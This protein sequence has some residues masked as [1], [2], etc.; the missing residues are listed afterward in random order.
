MGNQDALAGMRV[1]DCSQV[2]AGPFCTMLLADLG[3]EV[4][5]IEPP[6]GD[7]TRAMA[8]PERGESASYWG[9]ITRSSSTP[10]SLDLARTV[11]TRRAGDLISSPRGCPESCRSRETPGCRR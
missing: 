11:R 7:S 8:G 9:A 10:R 3:A 4:I 5:K 2:M 1:L 6:S